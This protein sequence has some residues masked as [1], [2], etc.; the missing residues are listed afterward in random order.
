LRCISFDYPPQNTRDFVGIQ[1]WD[2]T[3][4]TLFAIHMRTLSAS[5]HLS[6]SNKQSFDIATS[7]G[8]FIQFAAAVPAEADENVHRYEELI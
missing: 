4:A 1:N 8:V 6:S 5:P 7:H 2:Q 3:H